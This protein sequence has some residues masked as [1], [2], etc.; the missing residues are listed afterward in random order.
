MRAP[1][2]RVCWG[3]AG[4]GRGPP[5]QMELLPSKALPSKAGDG[6]LTAGADGLRCSMDPV[7]RRAIFSVMLCGSR[8]GP[9]G[10]HGTAADAAGVCA[11]VPRGWRRL[12][13]PSRARCLAE[14]AR[15]VTWRWAAARPR[16]S[17]ALGRRR[18]PRTRNGGG[19]WRVSRSDVKAE[20]QRR[21]T[22]YLACATERVPLCVH[23]GWRPP[24]SVGFAK[25]RR[26]GR[27]HWTRWCAGAG[28]EW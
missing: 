13:L 14:H 5:I 27:G 15:P 10:V 4:W 24:L 11:R 12:R 1:P 26:A 18:L 2:P 7:D 23:A 28:G 16:H 21:P 3:D 8:G 20:G 25:R 22:G 19:T 17:T 9:F 6:L